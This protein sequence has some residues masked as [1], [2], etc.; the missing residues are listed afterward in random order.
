[1]CR[2][3]PFDRPDP[4][5]GGPPQVPPASPQRKMVVQVRFGA[6]PDLLQVLLLQRV[7]KV[8]HSTVF[9]LS[10]CRLGLITPFPAKKTVP[11]TAGTEI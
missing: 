11:A 10:C 2:P 7:N 6:R 5:A 9:L 4:Y 3:R 1:M 8:I